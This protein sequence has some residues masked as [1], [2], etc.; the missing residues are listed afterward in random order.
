MP[1]FQRLLPS[2]A[3]KVADQL[4]VKDLFPRVDPLRRGP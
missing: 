3:H 4:L 2:A 1:A